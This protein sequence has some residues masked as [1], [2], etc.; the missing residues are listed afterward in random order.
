MNLVAKEYVAAKNDR[1]GVLVLSRFTG[2]ARELDQALLINPYDTETFADTLVTAFSMEGEERAVRMQR[3]R[4]TVKSNNIYR[5]AGKIL[6]TLDS[7]SQKPQLSHAV[8]TTSV[9]ITALASG[10]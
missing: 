1:E 6:T 8:S 5:W 10:A 3:L 7:L 2:A 4:D 9:E